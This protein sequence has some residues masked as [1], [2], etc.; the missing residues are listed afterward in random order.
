MPDFVQVSRRSTAFMVTDGVAT[1]SC[2]VDADGI[3]RWNDSPA[4]GRWQD[5]PSQE[6]LSNVNVPSQ[7][8]SRSVPR[9]QRHGVSGR[10]GSSFPEGHHVFLREGAPFRAAVV[11]V[12]WWVA[13]KEV[14]T[15]GHVWTNARHLDAVTDLFKVVCSAVGVAP[16]FSAKQKLALPRAPQRHAT[17]HR[18]TTSPNAT[19]TL[20]N[21][22][23]CVFFLPPFVN[24]QFPDIFSSRRVSLFGQKE[25]F[26]SGCPGTQLKIIFTW[27]SMDTCRFVKPLFSMMVFVVAVCGRHCLFC[28]AA[29]TDQQPVCAIVCL[30][31]RVSLAASLDVLKATA[32]THFWNSFL[33]LRIGQRKSVRCDA[34]KRLLMSAAAAGMQET[35]ARKGSSVHF[36]GRRRGRDWTVGDFFLT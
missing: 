22:S 12:L 29:S 4:Q 19:H 16:I 20:A 34:R 21:W 36:G 18:N 32:S 7:P 26:C 17:P 25:P 27:S 24:V 13:S 11:D 3:P 28:D 1:R 2:W 9:P 33:V 14:P 6:P 8:H 30:H 5:H 10:V 23:Y 15:S 35:R 31:L